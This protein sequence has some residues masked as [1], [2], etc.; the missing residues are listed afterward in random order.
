M[1]YL[2][3]NIPAPQSTELASKLAL[4]LTDLTVEILK[5]KRELTSVTIEFVPPSQWFIATVPLE[6]AKT[7]Q[8]DIKVTEGTNTKDENARFVSE[9]FHAIESLLGEVH[10]ASYVTIHEVRGD[11]WGCREK[12]QK[13]RYIEGR[14]V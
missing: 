2:N 4:E 5:K 3:V 10:P 11:S 8:L 14:R 12:T 7:F 1:P 13:S 6:G 9:A